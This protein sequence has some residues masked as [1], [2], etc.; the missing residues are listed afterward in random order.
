MANR[1]TDRPQGR[2][3][4]Q[5]GS[6]KGYKTPTLTSYGSIVKLTQAGAGSGTDGGDPSM[7]MLCL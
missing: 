2:A 3:E 6:S 1:D 4:A 5:T 7:R